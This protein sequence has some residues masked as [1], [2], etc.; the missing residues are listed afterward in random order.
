MSNEGDN[1]LNKIWKAVNFQLLGGHK[2][3]ISS[4]L[5]Q[6]SVSLSVQVYIK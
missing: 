2:K 1:N 3:K 4:P 6:F 5:F